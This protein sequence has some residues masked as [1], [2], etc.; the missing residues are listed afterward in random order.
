[1]IN[2]KKIISGDYSVNLI[3]GGDL[4][5]NNESQNR[6]LDIKSARFLGLVHEEVQF[7][8]R[9]ELKLSLTPLFSENKMVFDCYGPM[10]D[11]RFN[12]ESEMPE[13]WIRKVHD[14]IIPNNRK[15]IKILDV[16]ISLINSEEKDAVNKFKQHVDDF[17]A[18]HTG[19][20]SSNGAVFPLEILKILE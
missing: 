12:P 7:S 14:Y 4:V 3:I 8:S 17:E 20:S 19:R 18:K 15:I 5:V 13:V 10:T 2:N 1:M 6:E 11:E 9:E 16:N